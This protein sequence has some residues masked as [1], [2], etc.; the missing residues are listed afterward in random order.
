M[1]KNTYPLWESRA[2]YYL[3]RALYRETRNY[4]EVARRMRLSRERV[5]QLIAEA[6]HR[7]RAMIVQPD[8]RYSRSS[9]YDIYR[10]YKNILD[11]E[12]S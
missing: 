10:A 9:P 4:A 12:A 2:R 7:D 11:K 3:A 1:P 5:Q 6:D 8:C